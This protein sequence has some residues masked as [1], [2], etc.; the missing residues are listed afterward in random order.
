VSPSDQ[1]AADRLLDLL[2]DG[3]LHVASLARKDGDDPVVPGTMGMKQSD[4][5]A[6]SRELVAAGMLR[7]EP[8]QRH[9]KRGG[10]MW[11]AA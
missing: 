9:G 6:A 3:P 11:F 8:G 5:Y 7:T 4:V 2:L 10:A 1:T